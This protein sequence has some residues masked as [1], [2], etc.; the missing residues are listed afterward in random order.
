MRGH[1][2]VANGLTMASL[3]CAF[4]TLVLAAEG[5]ILLALA[6]VAA[7]AVLDSIDG[8]LAR[9][10]GGTG[11]FGSQLDSLADHAAFGVAP[12]FMLH[13]AVLHAVPVAGPAATLAF[14]LAGGWRLARFS[15]DED[16]RLRF[17]GLPLP[18]SGLVLAAAAALEVAPGLALALVVVVGALMV[19]T[20]PFPTFAGLWRLR[21]SGVRGGDRRLDGGR[22]GQRARAGGDDGH[23]HPEPHEDERIGAPLFA[24]E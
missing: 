14:V 3:A 6:A 11:A 8:P 19:S 5:R 24:R 21:P 12:A 15:A 22:A 23:R 7:A 4:A 13:V 10:A 17:V 9:R 2:N 18:P 16:D 1:L 20:M